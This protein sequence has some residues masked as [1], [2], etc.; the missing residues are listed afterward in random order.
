VDIEGLLGAWFDLGSP[1]DEWQKYMSKIDRREAVIQQK[2]V[3][4]IQATVMGGLYLEL[5]A[6]LYFTDIEKIIDAWELPKVVKQKCIQ[7]F[8][9]WSVAEAT[10][11]GTKPEQICYSKE[12]PTKPFGSIVGYIVGNIIAWHLL[13]EPDCYVSPLQIGSDWQ[14]RDD[15]LAS[16][17]AVQLLSGYP[18]LSSGGLGQTIHASAA[19]LLRVLAVPARQE[20]FIGEK[21]GYGAGSDSSAGIVRIQLGK[22]SRPFQSADASL[23]KKGTIV[24]ESNIDDMNPEWAGHLILHLLSMGARDAYLI[25]IIMKK[26]RPGLQLRVVCSE[27]RQMEFQKEIV[28]QTTTIG[29]RYY[30]VKGWAVPHKVVNVQT[31]FGELPVKIAFLDDEI[32]NVAPEYEACRKVAETLGTSVKN[33]YQTALGEALTRYPLSV[34]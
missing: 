11:R 3:D 34:K 26:G 7:V 17:V 18:T 9:H 24:L 6:I 20:A 1:F 30:P 31:S 13:G 5:P 8:R 2:K 21:I 29:V 32:V 28:R 10:V 22:W 25:P 27:E 19:A 16:A 14:H 23:A 12:N 33:V 15:Q 4:G